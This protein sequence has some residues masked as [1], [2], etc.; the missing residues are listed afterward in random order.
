MGRCSILQNSRRLGR[1]GFVEISD[2]QRTFRTH[3]ADFPKTLQDLGKRVQH[4]ACPGRCGMVRAEKETKQDNK[5]KQHKQ[6]DKTNTKERSTH[7]KKNIKN[8]TNKDNTGTTQKRTHT[9]EARARRNNTHRGTTAHKEQQ[10]RTTA[11][12]K[13]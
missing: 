6:Q 3:T 2:F 8:N 10:H 1:S 13:K 12:K 7:Q 5:N 11:K 4:I 9:E